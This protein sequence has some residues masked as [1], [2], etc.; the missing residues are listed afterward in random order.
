LFWGREVTARKRAAAPSLRT[1]QARIRS[2]GKQTAAK[3]AAA[4][5][6]T[7]PGEYAEGLVFLGLNAATMRALAHE[8]RELPLDIV[9]RLLRSPSF[10]ERAVALLVMVHQMDDTDIAKRKRVFDLYLSK[11]RYVNSWG[12]VDCSAPGIVGR[13]LEN[14]NRAVLDRLAKSKSLWERRI[15]IVATQWLIRR[16]Q[17]DDPLRIAELLLGDR[18]DLIHKAAGW[19][20]REVG[21]RDQPRLERF[22]RKHLSELPRT[23]LRYAIERFPEPLRRAYLT[24]KLA[25][26]KRVE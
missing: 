24:G 18:E 17:L 8:F 4:F 1:I 14:R 25:G 10:D 9:E 23:T 16:G 7:R 20:L 13:Y 22:L 26:A 3:S 6:K 15:A 19:M 5:H 12:L 11:T 2:F 21:K